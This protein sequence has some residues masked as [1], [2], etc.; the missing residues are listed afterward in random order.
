MVAKQKELSVE[1]SS[2]TFCIV[3]PF[4]LQNYYFGNE[5]LHG[6]HSAG[7]ISERHGEFIQKQA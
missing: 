7:M 3:D 1:Y 4:H 2:L 5:Q 6:W